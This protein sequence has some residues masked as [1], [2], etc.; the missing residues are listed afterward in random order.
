MRQWQELF[1]SN[2]PR[3]ISV[4]LSGK[5]F[6]Q[7]DLTKQVKQTL[8]ETKLD[9]CSLRLEMKESMVM[10]K[11]ESATET[12]RQLRALG[13][14]LAIDGFGT[15]Y[16]SLSYLHRS[17]ISTLKV[18]RSFISK[19]RDGDKENWEI[20]RTIRLLADNLGMDL[21]AEGVETAQQ[22][23]HLRSL[24]CEYGQG[25]YFSEPVDSMA[26]AT[27]LAM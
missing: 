26:A 9:A 22:L 20:V 27:L 23:E 18:D 25:Y 24:R 11:S 10:E 8:H 15:G 7:A 13:V 1:P 17:P 12:L 19:I 16:S 3:T 5:Q 6:A 14:E 4:N 2:P 21:I